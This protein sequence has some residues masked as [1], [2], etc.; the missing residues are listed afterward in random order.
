M[1]FT[2][3]HP[4][5]L[6]QG[7]PPNSWAYE[8]FTFAEIV[9]EPTGSYNGSKTTIKHA[10]VP[11]RNRWTP[12]SADFMWSGR[13]NQ[14][15][16]FVRTLT[17]AG[18]AITFSSTLE[19]GPNTY[20]GTISDDEMALLNIIDNRMSSTPKPN[21]APYAR[22]EGAF[23]V[24]EPQPSLTRIHE[25]QS[26]FCSVDGTIDNNFNGFTHLGYADTSNSQG[27]GI[28]WRIN[29]PAGWYT[30]KWRYSNGPTV[31][32]RAKLIVNGNVEANGIS[33]PTTGSWTTWENTAAV[34][35]YLGGGTKNIRLE[36]S[37]DQGLAPIDRIDI[38][39]A[40]VSRV[41][42]NTSSRLLA[43]SDPDTKKQSISLFPNPAKDVIEIVGDYASIEVLS[44][45]GQLIKSFKKPQSN[46]QINDLPTGLYLVKILDK[47]GVSQIKKI[48]KL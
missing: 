45:S 6:Q 42:C 32:R 36:S 30:F 38:T 48:I 4:T 14:A 21:V 17:D 5:P 7:A 24:G 26:G 29:G 16:R 18:A 19:G 12:S 39:A 23:L 11:L 34:T 8:E 27:S 31:N 25:N 37:R 20:D 47:Y 41:N 44:I 22:P 9:A 33:F 28:N 1:D 10:F 3:G 43:I 13:T 35:V 15:Y 40:N 46:Y 2:G